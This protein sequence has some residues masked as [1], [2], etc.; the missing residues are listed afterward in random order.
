MKP[1][2]LLLLTIKSFLCY[3][4]PNNYKNT[5]KSYIEQYKN[6]AIREMQEYKIPASITLAQG[7]LES[8]AGTSELAVN[9]NNHF[10]IKCHKGW[11]GDSLHKDDDAKNECFR[12]YANA[13]ASFID[14]SKF[15]TSRPRYAFLFD[16]DISDYK[17]WCNGL[18][19]AGYA[20][21]PKYADILIKIIEENGLF[22]YDKVT[23]VVQNT[24][25][26][27]NTFQKIEAITEKQNNKNELDEFEPV[28]IGTSRRKVYINNRT[29]YILAQKGDN[30]ATIAADLELRTWQI[31]KY[32]E[33]KKET[34][35]HEGQVIYIKP[36]K[37]K[38]LVEHHTVKAGETMHSIA[39]Y[40]GIKLKFTYRNNLMQSGTEPSQGQQLWLKKQRKK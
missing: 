26:E 12:K 17:A 34:S 6:I 11:T 7:I 29:K 36:K 31:T 14:H 19:K 24:I 5:V 30:I 9:G 13:E 8:A 16:L 3:A 33:L 1:I 21:N 25:N 15:L 32:N 20:T 35:I 39:Q 4:Q 38:A 22:Q 40:Y 10:G 2:L 37:R 23:F 27:D 18:K 28:L